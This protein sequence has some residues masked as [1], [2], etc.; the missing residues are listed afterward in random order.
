MISAA[1][2]ARNLA[3]KENETEKPKVLGITVLTSLSNKDTNSLGWGR[4]IKEQSYKYASLALD[5]G[6]DGIV[7]SAHELTYL[8]EK[9]GNNF[10]IVTPGIRPVWAK[11]NDQK[12]V[13]TPSKAIKLGANYIVIGRPI[14]QSKNPELVIN[15]IAKQM[16]EDEDA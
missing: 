11:T 10:L 16:T 6:C 14:S 2:D 9:L 3:A 1:I 7:C 4:N 5:A 12:R 8:R 15:K 13:V